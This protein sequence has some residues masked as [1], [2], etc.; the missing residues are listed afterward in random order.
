MPDGQTS[1][2]PQL[3][4][5][6]LEG[7]SEL[8]KEVQLLAACRLE[9]PSK[10]RDA[11]GAVELPLTPLRQPAYRML[12]LSATMQDKRVGC[13]G[14]RVYGAKAL[15]SLSWTLKGHVVY[16]D[17]CIYSRSWWEMVSFNGI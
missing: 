2:E 5:L 12:R 4:A 7:L 15:L 3:L 8:Q 13:S 1:S 17:G 6:Q 14:L 9:L 11:P 16:G 10:A